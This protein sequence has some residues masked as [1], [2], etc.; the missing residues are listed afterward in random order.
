MLFRALFAQ[1]QTATFCHRALGLPRLSS[2]NHNGNGNGQGQFSCPIRGEEQFAITVELP[3]P[4]RENKSYG[5]FH[6]I[7]NEGSDVGELVL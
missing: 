3:N 7:V 4:V 2:C 6:A 5:E 1:R